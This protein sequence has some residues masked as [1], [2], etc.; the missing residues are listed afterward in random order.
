MTDAGLPVGVVDLIS[1]STRVRIDI[2]GR[3]SHTGGTPMHLRAD[4]LATAAQ[5]VLAGEELA[6]DSRHHGTR[7]TVGKLD[8]HP[9]SITTIPGH[10]QLHIDIRDTD[11]ERQRLSTTEL[12]A[13]ACEIAGSRDTGISVEV[14][15]DASPVVLPVKI[16]TAITDAAADLGIDYRVL[17]SGASHDTQMINHGC[18][19]GIIFVSGQNHGIS[20]SPDELTKYEDLAVGVELLAASLRHLDASSHSSNF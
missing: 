18:P 10:C 19:G 16:R 9:G 17:P 4:A 12:I 7:I 13:R 3:A 15:A 5:I 14:L 20:H 8:V 6:K 2:T 11:A 1:G